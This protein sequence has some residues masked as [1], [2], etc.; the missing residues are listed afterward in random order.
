MPCRVEYLCNVR[1]R[2]RAFILQ[3]HVSIV[4]NLD[5]AH[6]VM[7]SCNYL[8]SLPESQK[9]QV[10]L[11]RHGSGRHFPLMIVGNHNMWS[12]N[13]QWVLL[14]DRKIDYQVM[15]R[16]HILMTIFGHYFKSGACTLFKSGDC[17]VMAPKGRKHVNKGKHLCQ[18]VQ[19]FSLWVLCSGIC[20]HRHGVKARVSFLS[21]AWASDADHISLSFVSCRDLY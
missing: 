16:N 2:N 8:C 19:H 4:Y 1:A 17:I 10:V 7:R 9:Y 11:G 14:T 13:G 20:E 3:N 6:L 12:L 15:K 21:T 18:H 5:T